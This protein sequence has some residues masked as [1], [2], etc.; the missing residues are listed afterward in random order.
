M[1]VSTSKLSLSQAHANSWTGCKQVRAVGRRWGTDRNGKARV[2][3]CANCTQPLPADRFPINYLVA[4]L[5]ESDVWVGVNQEKNFLSWIICTPASDVTPIRSKSC[6]PIL[7]LTHCC[8]FA[9]SGDLVQ[10]FQ[11]KRNTWSNQVQWHE[12][13]ARDVNPSWS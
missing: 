5:G 4:S 11:H 9:A 8:G 13:I 2:N 3:W 1:R 10:D 7:F 12:T 6:F